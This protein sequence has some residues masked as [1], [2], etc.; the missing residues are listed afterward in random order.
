MTLKT[1]IHRD[2]LTIFRNPLL[3]KFRILQT[4]FTAITTAGLFARFTDDYEDYVNWRALNGFFF[5]LSLQAIN[6]SVTPVELIFPSE[7]MVFLKEEGAKLYT[8]LP[9]FL[10]RNI[11]EIPYSII[12]PLISVL[13]YYWFVGLS[14]TAVQFFIFYLITYLLTMNGTSLGL[15]LGSIITDAKSISTVTSL[16]LMPLFL[17]SG[18]FK[19]S[20]NIPAWF[21]WLQYLS[22]VKYGFSAYLQNEVMYVEK[23][24]IDELN[25]TTGL[26]TNIILLAVLAVAY[27]L[28]S[29]F[30]LW[31]MRQ[32]LQ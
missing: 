13:L 27:R 10:S 15:M 24:N 5:E 11:V 23:S 22:P 32:K 8:T 26:W 25:F 29:L 31:K 19:N 18:F 4:V 14:N 21:G 20:G 2:I 9:Y 28:V 7:R 30:F 3:V 17:L 6:N 12:I 16:L 1:L